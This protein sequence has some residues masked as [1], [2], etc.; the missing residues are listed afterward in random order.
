VDQAPAEKIIDIDDDWFDGH[1]RYGQ[2]VS[3][4]L[5]RISAIRHNADPAS[6]AQR[7]CNIDF[8][9]RWGAKGIYGDVGQQGM[10]V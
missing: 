8:D 7:A 4:T 9:Q 3:S 5:P 2:D 10:S 6:K 1:T